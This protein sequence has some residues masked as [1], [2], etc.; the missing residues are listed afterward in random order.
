MIKCIFVGHFSSKDYKNSLANSS[1]G[2]QVQ[3]QI[4]NEICNI[5]GGESAICFSM[6]PMPIWPKGDFFISSVKD[7][8]IFFPSYINL[9][10]FK[11]LIFSVKLIFFLFTKKP[12]KCIQYNSYLFE[13][14]SLLTYKFFL[15]KSGI[16]AIIQ[17]VNCNSKLNFSNFFNFKFLSERA[18][19]FLLKYFNFLIPVSNQIVNDF[20]LR[21]DNTFVFQGGL[22]N[23]SFKLLSSNTKFEKPKDKFAVFAGALE[24]YNGIDKIVAQWS[25]QKIEFPLHIFGRGTLSNFISTQANSSKYIVY[26]DFQSEEIVEKWIVN[27]HWNF[28]LRYSIDINQDYFFPSKFFNLICLKGTLLCNDFNNLPDYLLPFV[29]IIDD[30]L[31]G[32]SNKI[33]DTT[34]HLAVKNVELCMKTLI[35]HHN[36]HNCI[37]MLLKKL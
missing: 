1:A 6:Q 8:N 30:E 28:C 5:V 9:P 11:N 34:D 7:G 4:F 13:N 36:W 2:N 20:N 17:D 12:N 37:E 29:S 23:Y 22:T 35:K 33:N 10:I 16:S 32:L 21:R 31:I 19:L 24:P 14:L 3:L 18:G 15:G 27:A 25:K 26:H